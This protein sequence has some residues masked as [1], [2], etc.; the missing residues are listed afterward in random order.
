MKKF[1][2]FCLILATLVSC[3]SSCTVIGAVFLYKY[4]AG[5]KFEFLH[6]TS[7]I[8][9]IEIVIIGEI[10]KSEDTSADS[11]KTISTPQFETVCEVQDTAQFLSEFSEIKCTV[12]SPPSAPPIGDLAIKITYNN[13][14][15]DVI[16][17]TGQGEYRDGY[18]YGDSGKVSFDETQFKQL[19]NKYTSESDTNE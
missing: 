16:C 14:D 18:Y 9:T 19:I 10:E 6:D 11:H 4:F 2:S 5:T 1:I 13:G 12:S 3:L 7:E 17:H 15:Y 8:K